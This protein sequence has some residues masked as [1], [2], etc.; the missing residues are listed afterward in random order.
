[1]AKRKEYRKED[2]ENDNEIAF[3]KAEMF[4]GFVADEIELRQRFL[5]RFIHYF[6][7]QIECQTFYQYQ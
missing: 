7:L 4:F 6:L 1:M 2:L 3:L 5:S